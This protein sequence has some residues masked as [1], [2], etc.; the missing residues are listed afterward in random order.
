MFNT[1]S[2][3]SNVTEIR[4]SLN[5]TLLIL[6]LVLACGFWP[7]DKGFKSSSVCA[8]DYYTGSTEG[9]VEKQEVTQSLSE[10]LTLT[11]ALR[12]MY[13]KNWVRTGHS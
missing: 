3:L 4:C 5:A 2:Q 6:S 13:P 8:V 10:E 1:G 12:L 7:V 11:V 9:K